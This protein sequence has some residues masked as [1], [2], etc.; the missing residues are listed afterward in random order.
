MDSTTVKTERREENR[1]S[2]I[3]SR[4]REVENG[5][6]AARIG[7]WDA[8]KWLAAFLVVAIHTSPLESV[9]PYGDFLL[10]RIA[11]RL[12]VPFFFM[13]TG[14]FTVQVK[15]TEKKLF[16]LYLGVT[17]LYLP[18]QIY[19]YM[20][21]ETFTAGRILKDIFFDGTFYHLWYLPAC[22][23][24]LVLMT[25]LLKCGKEN[26]LAISILLYVIGLLGDSY[27]GLVRLS[28][29]LSKVYDGMFTCFS[30]T[31]NG[32]FMAPLF[33]LL[34]RLFR[35]Q[36]KKWKQNKDKKP[37]AAVIW[38]NRLEKELILF[39]CSFV[40]MIQEALL[41]HNTDW[42]R[43]DSMY[44]FLPLCSYH[45]FVFL[46]CINERAFPSER[47][48]QRT[49]RLWLKGPMYIYF[50]HPLVIILV[51]GCVKVIKMSALV[52]CSPL[53]YL[54]VCV[55]SFCVTAFL[56]LVQDMVKTK[57]KTGRTENTHEK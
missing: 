10:T 20:G 32:I 28:P 47:S 18:V 15:K 23:L 12:A 22:M 41:L 40:L 46:R 52:E 17:C 16:L 1:G 19:K 25:L 36:E 54:C 55:G 9:W 6:K 34:G 3:E 57:R 56:C 53:Y 13:L 11:A 26:A 27:F 35:E 4:G 50:L 33:L 31:R 7:S 8:F 24:G 45:L 30:Y 37:G 2:R 43:H 29:F 39:L 5:G 48:G 42:Q 21:G 38:N 51:R 44:L 49:G 14:Y